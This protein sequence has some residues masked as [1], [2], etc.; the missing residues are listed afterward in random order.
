MKNLSDRI[1]AAVTKSIHLSADH[2]ALSSL[3]NQVEG[4]S[5]F[6]ASD[7]RKMLIQGWEA[8]VDHFLDDGVIDLA[9][10]ERLVRFKNEY[11]L[12]EADLNANGSHSRVVKALVLR[13]VFEGVVP[14]RMRYDGTLSINLKKGENVVWIFAGCNYMEDKAKR[15]YVGGS[16][17]ASIKVMKGVYYRVGAFKGQTISTT[18]RVLVDNGYVVITDQHIYFA[19]PN[20]SLRIPYDKVVSFLPF[21]DGVGVIRDNQTAKPQI[22]VTGDGWFSYNLITNLA[23]L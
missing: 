23:K 3:L 18:E 21:E 16:R 14:Q 8:S 7:V 15:Q 22:F 12:S 5:H 20:K 19:G 9:E 11:N 2:T 4:S 17:G 1:T 10:E 13:D 6:S